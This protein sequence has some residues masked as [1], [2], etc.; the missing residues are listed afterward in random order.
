MLSITSMNIKSMKL[1]FQY[2]NGSISLKDYLKQIKPLDDKIDFLEVQKFS[3]HLE[4]NPVFE[5][6]SLKQLH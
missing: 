1:Y 2:R 6:S 3:C 5:I 4:D